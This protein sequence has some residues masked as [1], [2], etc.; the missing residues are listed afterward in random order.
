VCQNLFAMPTQS[1]G[2]VSIHTTTNNFESAGSYKLN[3]YSAESS[4]SRGK[5]AGLP[6]M[7]RI[8]F[9]AACGFV[10]TGCGSY[11]PSIPRFGFLHA[12]PLAEQVRIILE[13]EGAEARSF[14]EPTCQTPCD[15]TVPAG[16][17]FLVTVE[18]NR[19]QTVTVPVH[20]ASPGGIPQPNPV[21]A[22]L[23]PISPPKPARKPATKRKPNPV[24]AQ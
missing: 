24:P 13:P 16:S 12:S 19:Y 18:R 17:E 9:I 20:P 5:G 21:V 2:R 15:F 7:N 11:I 10:L 3:C 1:L 22:Q 14:Q 4:P 6:M 23:Q 8:M